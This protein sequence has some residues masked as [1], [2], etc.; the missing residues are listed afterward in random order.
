ME[1]ATTFEMAMGAKR[2]ATKLKIGYY[3]INSII[4]FTN[5]SV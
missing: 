3:F 5:T 4:I 2:L 1:T